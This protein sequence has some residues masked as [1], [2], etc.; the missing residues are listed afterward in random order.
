MGVWPDGGPPVPRTFLIGPDE[1]PAGLDDPHRGLVGR[2][3]SGTPDVPS[4]KVDP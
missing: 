1:L 3:P 4:G 2:R